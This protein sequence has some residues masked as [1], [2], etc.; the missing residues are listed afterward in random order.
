MKKL[1]IACTLF[2]SA[3]S[4]T[5]FAEGGAD[6]VFERNEARVQQ[7]LSAQ[8]KTKTENQNTAKSNIEPN[9]KSS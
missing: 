2:L 3:L 4:S 5:A 6:R 8:E 9:A 1:I 7:A